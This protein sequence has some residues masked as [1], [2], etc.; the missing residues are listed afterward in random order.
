MPLSA[1]PWYLYNEQ[2]QDDECDSSYRGTN[3]LDHRWRKWQKMTSVINQIRVAIINETSHD[4]SVHSM[5]TYSGS[6]GCLVYQKT[7]FTYY[8]NMTNTW[9]QRDMIAGYGFDCGP[10]SVARGHGWPSGDVCKEKWAE[11]S[12]PWSEF[13]YCTRWWT[14]HASLSN[15]CERSKSKEYDSHFLGK[16]S[17]SYCSLHFEIRRDT[18]GSLCVRVPIWDKLT[19]IDAGHAWLML[20]L[21]ASISSA[22]PA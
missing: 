3:H 15:R 19:P 20:L 5:R 2:E 21:T 10:L 16:L 12:P 17:V 18:C 9:I 6:T 8:H 14:G 7:C 4:L 22:L 1:D 11:L 13:Y